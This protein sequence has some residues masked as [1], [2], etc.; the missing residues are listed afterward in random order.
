LFSSIV[1]GGGQGNIP[2]THGTTSA[3]YCGG[4]QGETNSEPGS[5]KKNRY[6]RKFIKVFMERKKK[7]RIKEESLARSLEIERQH[8]I[9]ENL[10]SLHRFVRKSHRRVKT[11]DKASIPFTFIKKRPNLDQST[12][13]NRDDSLIYAKPNKSSRSKNRKGREERGSADKAVTASGG[14]KVSD[15]MSGSACREFMGDSSS[16]MSIEFYTEYFNVLNSM[17]KD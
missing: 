12:L 8:K 2:N 15:G 10:I 11:S 17:Q 9:K 5:K 6:D 1:L 3:L 4:N 14:N 13:I 16:R 7:I